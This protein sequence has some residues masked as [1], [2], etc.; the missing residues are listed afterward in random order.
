MF[1]NIKTEVY[2]ISNSTLPL[3]YLQATY[4]EED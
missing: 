1:Y 4:A 2:P 3:S